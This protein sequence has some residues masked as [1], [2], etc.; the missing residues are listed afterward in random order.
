[1]RLALTA[2]QLENLVKLVYLGHW[3][4]NSWRSED[5]VPEFDDVLE[6]VLTAARTSGLERLAEGGSEDKRVEASEALADEVQPYLDFFNENTFWDE[7]I[8]RMADRDY[9]RKYGDE[10]LDQLETEEGMKR[11]APFI[12]R[13]E[14]EFT[15]HG[16]DRL[17]IR[18]DH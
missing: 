11:E 10:A 9:A 16:L 5:R 7:L 6:H 14:K 2:A 12:E 13:Y 4:A 3:V 8:F 15:A 17:E 1:M 18:R